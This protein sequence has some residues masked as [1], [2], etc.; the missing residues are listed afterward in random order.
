MNAI[1]TKQQNAERAVQAQQGRQRYI[2]YSLK[3]LQVKYLH[4]ERTQENPMENPNAMW[5]EFSTRTIQTDVSFQVSSNLL[6]DE[7]QTKV[8]LATLGQEMKNL[9]SELQENSC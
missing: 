4:N 5:N 2:D 7:E 8:Q 3:G 9:R 1:E 6:N